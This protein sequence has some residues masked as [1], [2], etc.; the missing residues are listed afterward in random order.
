MCE[1]KVTLENRTVFENAVYAKT[2]G[3][4][5]VLRDALGASLEVENC[6]ITEVDVRTEQLTLTKI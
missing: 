1:F 5:V 2:I 3:K 4:N 6:V